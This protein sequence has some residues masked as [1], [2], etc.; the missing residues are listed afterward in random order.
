ME[1][2]TWLTCIPLLHPPL[3]HVFLLHLKNLQQSREV[4]IQIYVVAVET[5][6]SLFTHRLPSADKKYL[7]I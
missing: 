1:M 2:E 6:S 5:H 3:P 7:R 4:F